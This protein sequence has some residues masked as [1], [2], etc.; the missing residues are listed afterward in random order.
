MKLVIDYPIEYADMKY[1]DANFVLAPLLEN[2]NYL[3]NIMKAK[4]N[5]RPLMMDNGAWEFGK[6]MDVKEYIKL[7]IKLEPE[8]LVVPDAMK[9]PDESFAL[10][11][12]FFMHWIANGANVHTKV[13][14]AP[15]GKTMG[16]MIDNYTMVVEEWFS[17]INILGVPKHVGSWMNRIKFTNDLFKAAPIKFRNVHFLGLWENEDF[18][19]QKQGDWHLNSIDTKAPFKIATGVNKWKSQMEYY[20]YKGQVNLDGLIFASKAI[21]SSMEGINND[22]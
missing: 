10:A 4:V 18:T 9:D 6:S 15:Q 17:Y 1:G 5:N 14:F 19:V 20:N 7:A 12:E 2:S 13:I 16:E 22:N 11:E 21:K 3:F 8:W